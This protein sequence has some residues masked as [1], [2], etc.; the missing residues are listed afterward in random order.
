MG[1]TKNLR[2]FLFSD[3]LKAIVIL[4]DVKKMPRNAN[5]KNQRAQFLF[6]LVKSIWKLGPSFNKKQ[7]QT[8]FLPSQGWGPNTTSVEVLI[9]PQSS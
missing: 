5:S 2:S 3:M 9:K 4:S 1:K 6:D 8:P 7:H